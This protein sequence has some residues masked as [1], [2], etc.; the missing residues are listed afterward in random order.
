LLEVFL[1]TTH[2]FPLWCR[3]VSRT[4][5][6][7]HPRASSVQQHIFACK[8]NLCC[9]FCDSAILVVIARRNFEHL[10]Y[11]ACALV[12]RNECSDPRVHS[13]KAM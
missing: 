11:F 5:P 9:N 13:S 12:N 6:G 8:S 10:T 4:C 1:H 3:G 7:R 2:C